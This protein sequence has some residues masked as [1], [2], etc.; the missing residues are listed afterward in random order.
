MVANEVTFRAA[1]ETV[2]S[3]AEEL[4]VTDSV[5][6]L[7]ECSL[8]GCREVVLMTPAQ[9]REIRAEPTHFFVISSH[10]ESGA[11]EGRALYSRDGYVVVEKTG[12]AAT[13]ARERPAR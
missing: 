8:E 3:R 2:E 13:I 1:N 5:P 9:Y 11:E 4:G 12:R 10:V 7:C 6:L